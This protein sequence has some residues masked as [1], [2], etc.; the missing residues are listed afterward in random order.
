MRA[1]YEI[2]QLLSNPSKPTFCWEDAILFLKKNWPEDAPD[3]VS[4]FIESIS[5]ITFDSKNLVLVLEIDNN[6]TRSVI[7]QRYY[8][9]LRRAV[10]YAFGENVRISFIL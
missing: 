4:R 2:R 3:D 5:F 10:N 1:A 9:F 8:D 7:E 6:E